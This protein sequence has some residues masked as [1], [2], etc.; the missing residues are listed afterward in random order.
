LWIKASHT[1]DVAL[2]RRLDRL[3]LAA[4]AVGVLIVGLGGG[5]YV[6][7]YPPCS[8]KRTSRCL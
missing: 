7:Q 5:F 1:K 3:A 4:A 8:A 6:G 2:A